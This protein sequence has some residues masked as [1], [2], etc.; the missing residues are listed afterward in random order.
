[1]GIM[2]PGHTFT[3]EPM[4]SEGRFVSVYLCMCVSVCMYV[5]VCVCIPYY[6]SDSS[7]VPGVMPHGL[8]TGQ[9]LLW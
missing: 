4:I 9:Q 8:T 7:Q 3:I 1:M 2:K 5:Y 6:D